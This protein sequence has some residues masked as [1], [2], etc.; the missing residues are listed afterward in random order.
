MGDTGLE[1]V[2]PCLSNESKAF[3]TNFITAWFSVSYV[4]ITQTNNSLWLYSFPA[5]SCGVLVISLESTTFWLQSDYSGK[6]AVTI[7]KKTMDIFEFKRKRRKQYL[8]NI[9]LIVFESR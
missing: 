3:F 8:I 1:P 5:E 9:L 7:T 2:T 6:T 4:A